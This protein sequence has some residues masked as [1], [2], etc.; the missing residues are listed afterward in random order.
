[1]AVSTEDL[2]GW[3]KR[4]AG[5]IADNKAYLVELDAAIG[6]ADHGENLD[7]GMRAAV[8]KLA[9]SDPATPSDVLKTVATQLISKV[10][11][12]AGPLYGTAFLRAQAVVAGKPELEPADLFAALRAG[13]GGVVARGKAELGDKTMVDAW[14]PAVDAGEAALANGQ[15]LKA[16]LAA[17]ADAAEAGMRATTPLI[18]RKGRASYL[19]ERSAGHQDP[20]ATSTAL[21]FR[22]LADA[23]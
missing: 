7:R 3:I 19:G 5:V 20:G 12:A 10:G 1:M 6:D 22:T 16:A 21:L 18:A 2:V 15:D 17:A 23:G 9:E 13:L 8:E 14:S 11:G 4:Y